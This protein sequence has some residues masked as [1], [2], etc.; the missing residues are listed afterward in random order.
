MMSPD[1]IGHL[2]RGLREKSGRS[3][4]EQAQRL[5]HVSGRIVDPENIKRWE[6]EKRLPIPDWHNALAEG[7]G[8]PVEEVRRAVTASRRYRR[9]MS[10]S[11]L[12]EDEEEVAPVERRE[13]LGFSALAAGV[14]TEPWGRLAA[15]IAGPSVDQEA[16]NELIGK[17]A[18]LFISEHRLPARQLANRLGQHLDT[19]TAL[20]PRSGPY[21]TTLTIAAGETAALAGWAAYDIGDLTTAQH[22]YKTAALAGREAGHPAVVALAMGYASYAVTSGK[23]REMLASAQEHVRGS[24][25]AAARSWLAAREAEEAAAVSDRE[26]AVRALDRAITAFD[27]ANPDSEQPWIRFY[28]RPRLDSLTVSTYARLRHRDL[29]KSAQDALTHLG[30][31]DSKVRIAVLADVATGYVVA[32]DVDQGVEVGQDFVRAAMATPTSVGRTRL[33][34]FAE[35]LPTEHNAAQD[36][37]EDIRAALLV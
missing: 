5:E 31:D 27:Y 24:G 6:T 20:I 25:Y 10:T 13:F 37:A 34:A 17:T 18:D 23:A 33:A 12:L 21:R 15:A 32:G 9:L 8:I 1:G 7:Y 14:A 11:V 3:R 2:L 29:E 30:E 22:Y 28:Q 4:R 16:S 26:G 35:V 19:L 36:L